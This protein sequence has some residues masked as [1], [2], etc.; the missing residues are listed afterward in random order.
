[1]CIG[2]PSMAMGSPPALPPPPPP[3]PTEVD[4]GVQRSREEQKRRAAAMQ[5]Y[6]SRI[7][8]SPLGVTAPAATTAGKALLGS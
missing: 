8:S 1:M 5:G 4:P 7:T 6:A 2:A 3:A